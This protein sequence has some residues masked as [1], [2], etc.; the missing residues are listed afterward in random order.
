VRPTL[1]QP[2]S[3]I[4]STLIS[5]ERTAARNQMILYMGSVLR[6]RFSGDQRML[7]ASPN[8]P[9]LLAAGDDGAIEM[10]RRLVTL[11]ARPWMPLA[12]AGVGVIL[13]LPSVGGGLLGDDYFHRSVLLGVGDA[14]AGSSPLFDLF[15]FASGASRHR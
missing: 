9:L 3:T 15:S 14:G 11:L 8:L 13:S 4:R 10:W 1:T 12:S 7:S 2:A 6:R 5:E